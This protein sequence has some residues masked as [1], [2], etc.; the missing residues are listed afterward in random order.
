[1]SWFVPPAV[2][3]PEKLISVR[4]AWPFV[5]VTGFGAGAASALARV[6]VDLST[7]VNPDAR[8]SHRIMAALLEHY[9]ASTGDR[10]LGLRAGQSMEAGDLD[11]V[12]FAAR[13]C[14][15]LRESIHCCSRYVRLMNEA[16]EITLVEGGGDALWRFRT[17]DGVREPPAANDFVVT[18]ALSFSRRY[19]GLKEPPIEVHVMH[20]E[21]EYAAEYARLL[22]AHVRFSMPHNGVLFPRQDLD[23]PMLRAQPAVQSAFEARARKLAERVGPQGVAQRVAELVVEQLESAEVSMTSVARD[24]AMSVATLRRRLDEEGTSFSRIVDDAR[25]DLAQAFLRDRRLTIGEIAGRL[26]FSHAPAFYG[27]FR[28]WTGTTPSDYRDREGGAHPPSGELPPGGYERE[29]ETGA[30]SGMELEMN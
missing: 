26:G 11:I 23:R 27:A 20:P 22:G 18:S 2:P 4:L 3:V 9:V 8:V 19:A 7:F 6:G 25:R 30:E 24:L 1:V 28:R 5:R 13:S 21:P 16:A 29:T 10:V 14:S 17:N 12:E 15:S